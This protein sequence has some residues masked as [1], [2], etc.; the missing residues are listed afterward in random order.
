MRDIT[1]VQI[2]LAAIAALLCIIEI[3]IILK[4]G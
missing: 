3:T 4:W 2:Q 1:A